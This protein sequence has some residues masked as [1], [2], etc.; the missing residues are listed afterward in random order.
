MWFYIK[1]LTKAYYI[2][3]N[4]FVN[5]S[6]SKWRNKYRQV[7]F[8]MNSW[9]STLQPFFYFLLT[10]SHP[11]LSTVLPLIIISL[12]SPVFRLH[13]GPSYFI[14][15][16]SVIKIEEK[17]NINPKTLHVFLDEYYCENT[18]RSRLKKNIKFGCSLQIKHFFPVKCC[19]LWIQ[20]PELAQRT[21]V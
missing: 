14:Y 21:S 10:S 17:Q 19:N 18:D 13:L 9:T 16:S 11:S 7:V 15:T 4:I 5:L 3:A 20:H 8:S 12:F 2:Y 1:R 6:A